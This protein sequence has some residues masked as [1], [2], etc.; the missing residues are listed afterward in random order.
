MRLYLPLILLFYKYNVFCFGSIE[1]LVH[2][3]EKDELHRKM[4]RLEGKISME[5]KAGI[6]K[7]SIQEFEDYLFT[8][9]ELKKNER[10]I[11]VDG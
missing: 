8:G 1:P 4:R 9:M 2:V 6:K 10:R 5:E 3:S 7:M 11:P